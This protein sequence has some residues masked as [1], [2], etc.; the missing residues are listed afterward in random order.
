[1]RYHEYY[2]EYYI[3]FYKVSE[4]VITVFFTLVTLNV[5]LVII[6]SVKAGVGTSIK[7][8]ILIV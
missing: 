1:M 5:G 4:S 8:F 3:W 7:S 6:A 2:M